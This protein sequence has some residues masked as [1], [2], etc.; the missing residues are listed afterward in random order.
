MSTKSSRFKDFLGYD[1][2]QRYFNKKDDNYESKRNDYRSSFRKPSTRERQLEKK[3][4]FKKCEA[5][6][7]VGEPFIGHDLKTCQNIL[8]SDSESMMKTFNFEVDDVEDDVII[9]GRGESANVIAPEGNYYNEQVEV[10][11]VNIVESPKFHVI[12]NKPMTTMVQDTGATGSMI[13]LEICELANF[14]HPVLV[15]YIHR[16]C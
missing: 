12:I 11:R 14:N 2:P 9:E 13:S 6:R 7:K 3:F 5:P 10:E 8:P 16:F 15:R 4:Y 1:S